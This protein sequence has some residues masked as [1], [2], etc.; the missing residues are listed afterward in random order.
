MQRKKPEGLHASESDVAVPGGAE[1]DDSHRREGLW[2]AAILSALL[3][4]TLV[5]VTV[6]SETAPL[7][8]TLCHASNRTDAAHAGDSCWSCHDQGTVESRAARPARMADMAFALP[9]PGQQLVSSV[10]DSSCL[11]CHTSILTEIVTNKGIRVRHACFADT[12]HCTS[13]HGIHSPAPGQPVLDRCAECHNETGEA[14]ACPTCHVNTFPGIASATGWLA[15]AHRG[16]GQSH[17]VGGT[18]A[19]VLCHKSAECRSCHGIQLPHGEIG[20][21]R[22]GHGADAAAHRDQCRLCHDEGECSACHRI[23]MPH[24]AGF[25]SRHVSEASEMGEKLC[26]ACHLDDDCMRC[27]VQHI[28][29]NPPIPRTRRQ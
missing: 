20:A 11:R 17:G 2:V 21:W 18:S 24:P 6:A 29:A 4:L 7:S 22:Q 5:G 8:C 19:C 10:A 3:L 25:L 27:H 9:W 14:A 1:T 26:M 12:Q 13:C 28:H 23:P 15:L 16:S